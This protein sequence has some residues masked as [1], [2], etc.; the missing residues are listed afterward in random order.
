MA[1]G[2]THERLPRT[3]AG[4]GPHGNALLLGA[5]AKV[6]TPPS[7]CWRMPANVMLIA[8]LRRSGNLKIIKA[9]NLAV[10]EQ[11]EGQGSQQASNVGAQAQ[12][13]LLVTVRREQSAE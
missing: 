7:I 11:G 8:L 10:T 1:T 6:T 9:N 13:A 5:V 4:Q 2:I 12:Q 3:G